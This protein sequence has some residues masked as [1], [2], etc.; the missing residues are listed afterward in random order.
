MPTLLPLYRLFREKIIT[1]RQNSTSTTARLADFV[2]GQG[3]K[4]NASSQK[5]TWMS[6][7]ED[8]FSVPQNAEWAN[9]TSHTFVR[10]GKAGDEDVE[11]Q[12]PIVESQ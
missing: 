2:F 4:T 10:I 9:S 3:H 7:K 5:P 12:T 11:M 8:K 1:A 6:R